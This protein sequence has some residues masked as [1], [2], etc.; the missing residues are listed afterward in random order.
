MM[1]ILDRAT[2][3][4]AAFFIGLGAV[5]FYVSALSFIVVAIAKP[6]TPQSV[7]MWWGEKAF[8][9]GYLS[10]VPE[11]TSELLGY[12]IIPVALVAA[13][14]CY[15]AGTALMKWGGRILLRKAPVSP[16]R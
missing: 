2:R 1:A 4:F 13:V 15:I 16:P 5:T 7:G 11:N 14:L 10:P 6:I 12:W 9:I 3:S 8:S